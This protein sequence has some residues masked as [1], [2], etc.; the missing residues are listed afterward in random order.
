MKTA[1]AA[2]QDTARSFMGR[3]LLGCK[4][5][6]KLKQSVARILRL[7][8]RTSGLNTAPVKVK[9]EFDDD[10]DRRLMAELGLSRSAT[11]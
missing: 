5:E 8:S 10:L 11:I 6:A 4:T 9:S 2:L 7:V 3:L 1:A